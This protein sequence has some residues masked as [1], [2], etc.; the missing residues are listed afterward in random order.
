MDY[1]MVLGYNYSNL[2]MRWLQTNVPHSVAGHF[3]GHTDALEQY[4]AHQLIHH[5]QGFT[6]SHWM[7]PSAA[8]GQLLTPYYPGGRQG[9]NQQNNNA[10]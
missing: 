3:D 5:D 8:I 10:Q 9:N 2:K 6:G 7:P 4:G 1:N